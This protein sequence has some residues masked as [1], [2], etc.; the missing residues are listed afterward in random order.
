MDIQGLIGSNMKNEM[1]EGNGMPD[2]EG[3]PSIDDKT[4]D[5]YQ[6]VVMAGLKALYSP[7]TR[8]V[9]MKGL[10]REGDI[11][12]VVAGEVAGLVKSLDQKSG[13]KIPKQ[14]IIPAAVAL[15]L[16]VFKFIEDSGKAKVTEDVVS[17]GMK[18]LS[19]LLIAEYKA[20]GLQGAQTG[21]QPP[22]QSPMQGGQMQQMQPPQSAPPQPQA[23]QPA[24]MGA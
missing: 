22:A 5:A 18:L 14:I 13:M 10:A 7:Q 15:M 24:M 20:M 4:K 17:R 23:Q 9:L 8:Q 11:A 1:P 16:D 2:E 6:R 3:K 21:Q 12:E 19:Q